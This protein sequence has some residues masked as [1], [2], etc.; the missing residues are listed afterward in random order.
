MNDNLN[1]VKLLR[2]HKNNYFRYRD[3]IHFPMIIGIPKEIKNNE[4]R[5]SLTPEHVAALALTHNVIVQRSAGLG[6]GFSDESYAVAGAKLVDTLQDVYDQATCIVKVKEP[7]SEEYPFIQSK[8]TIYTFFHFA[9]SE[10]LTIA[11][12]QSGATCIAY[13]TVEDNDGKL[14]LLTPMSEVAGRLAGQQ[15]AKYLEKPQGGSGILVGGVTG[16]PPAKAMVLGGGIVGT[17]AADVLV[18]MGADVFMFDISEKRLKELVAY[19]DGKI[20]PVLST[21]ENIKAHLPLVDTVIGA[22][23]IKGAKAPKLISKDMLSLMRPNTVLVDVSVDQGG[24]FETTYP[25]THECPTYT[26][27]GILHYAVANMPG[28]V[29]RTSTKA[30][31]RATFPYLMKLT[32]TPLNRLDN[33]F[34][35]GINAY[36]GH[37]TNKEVANAFQLPYTLLSNILD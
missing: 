8:H 21:T 16:V 1:Y 28:A 25:T 35:N 37:I 30:L 5:V 18:G 11:M 27:D 29:P 34:K 36:K 20:T 19:F 33:A 3:K 26:V 15:A 31:S 13:E 9:A 6:S 2:C 10:A 23:L 4:F 22:V 32:S 7:L 17:N 12:Q 24:C 14:P